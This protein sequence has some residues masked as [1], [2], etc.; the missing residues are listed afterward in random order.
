MSEIE[1][2]KIVRLD[3]PDGYCIINKSDLQPGDVLYGEEVKEPT[4]K[5]PQSR[6]VQ[7]KKTLI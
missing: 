2:V 6:K 3:V 4:K 7:V 1:T 5:G